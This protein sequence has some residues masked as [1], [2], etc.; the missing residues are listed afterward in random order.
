M[1]TIREYM[2]EGIKRGYVKNDA[3]IAVKCGVTQATVS[4]WRS[5]DRIPEDEEVMELAETLGEDPYE[6]LAV[7][8]YHKAKNEE[9][10][11]AWEGIV[12]KI[13]GLT[14]ILCLLLSHPGDVQAENTLYFNHLLFSEVKSNG[15]ASVHACV[16]SGYQP[17]LRPALLLTVVGADC[18]FVGPREPP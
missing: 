10:K 1:R 8:R 18:P 16:Q 3:L 7:A 5:G 6:M 4:R 2:D 17:F 11:T 14:V 13:G 12:R 9:T 15:Q